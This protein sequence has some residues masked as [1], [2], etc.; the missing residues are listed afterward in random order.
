MLRKIAGVRRM[1]H[2]R[3]DNIRAQAERHCG[4]GGQREKFGRNR[5]IEEQI[6]SMT[7]MVMSG[8]APGK[9]PRGGQESNGVMLTD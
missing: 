1:D 4:A 7:E 3:N 9:R 5:Y 2:V 6:G 8:A